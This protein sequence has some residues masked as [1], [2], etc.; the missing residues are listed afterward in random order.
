M[1]H[2]VFDTPPRDFAEDLRMSVDTATLAGEDTTLTAS[3]GRAPRPPEDELERGTMVGRYVVLGKLGAGGMG[4]V[5]AAYDP[6]LD[7]KVAVKLLRAGISASVEARTR[8]LRE[9][10]ALARLGHPNVVAVHDTG[11]VGERVWLAM[12]FVEG[13]TLAAWCAG[14]TQGRS[15]WRDVLAAMMHAGR[16]L[17][18]AH[19]AGLVHRDFKPDNVMVSRDGRVRVMDLGLARRGADAAER[20]AQSGP[21]N[22]ILS[23]HLTQDGAVMGTPAYMAPRA[24]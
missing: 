24:V 2:A 12:E 16:G 19:E 20:A 6:E 18:A 7:R 13:Q 15:R 22:G 5:Y 8:L 9:A 14:Q 17:Q 21:G 10:Q 23:L 4:V 11:S 3:Q 1:R